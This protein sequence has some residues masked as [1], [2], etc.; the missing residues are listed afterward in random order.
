MYAICIDGAKLEMIHFRLGI[1]HNHD[2]LTAFKTILQRFTFWF[3]GWY[4]FIKLADEFHEIDRTVSI[5]TGNCTKGTI[6]KHQRDLQTHHHI[7]STTLHIDLQAIAIL[8]GR[9]LEKLQITRR[10]TLPT[11]LAKVEDARLA[12]VPK[13]LGEM[14]IGRKLDGA[15]SDNVPRCIGGGRDGA[16]WKVPVWIVLLTGRVPVGKRS[17]YV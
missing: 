11:Q 4:A 5:S 16:V 2:R 12:E 15:D 9:F 17:D 3:S 13:K 7:V 10:F 1:T 6:R 8:S 14:V